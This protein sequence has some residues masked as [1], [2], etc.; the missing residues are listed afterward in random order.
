MTPILTLRKVTRESLRPSYN[1]NVS[2]VGQKD[3][4]P[5]GA[6]ADVGVCADNIDHDTAIPEISTHEVV[7]PAASFL[8]GDVSYAVAI[9]PSEAKC[10]DE[11]DVMV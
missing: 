8:I 4:I 2:E 7:E 5:S 3:K 9:Y 10:D 1:S 11:L 6:S